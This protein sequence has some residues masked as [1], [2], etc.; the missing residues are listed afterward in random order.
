MRRFLILLLA[1]PG[2]AAALAQLDLEVRLDP[3]TRE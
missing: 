2:I 1:W 3:A